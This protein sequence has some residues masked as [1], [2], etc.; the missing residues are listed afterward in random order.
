M[1]QVVYACT[2]VAFDACS[3]LLKCRRTLKWSY[4][5]AFFEGNAHARELFE[6]TQKVNRL[7]IPL[8][9]CALAH[10][11]SVC[12]CVCVQICTCVCVC[13]HAFYLYFLK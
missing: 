11:N 5:Y 2:G 1:S 12:V 13:I 9:S 6:F 8:C 3:T 7:R 10:M 4:V